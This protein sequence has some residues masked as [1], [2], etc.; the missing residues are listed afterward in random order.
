V[1]GAEYLRLS[2]TFSSYHN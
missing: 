2:T 1:K